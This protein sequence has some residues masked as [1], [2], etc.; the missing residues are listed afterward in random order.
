MPIP[1][2]HETFFLDQNFS[3]AYNQITVFRVPFPFER[4]DMPTHKLRDRN[5]RSQKPLRKRLLRALDRRRGIKTKP[6]KT[7][8]RLA[9]Q[10]EIE[11]KIQAQQRA[12]E[13]QEAAS[14][15]RRK[16]PPVQTSSHSVEEEQRRRGRASG[17]TDARQGYNMS[18]RMP[19]V[20]ASYT[21]EFQSAYLEAY[22]AVRDGRL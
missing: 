17:E 19:Q 1:A 21:D 10:L 11:R 22:Q 7:V 5:Q 12:R 4:A 9:A 2:L 3:F 6:L 20:F 15:R 8:I 13:R 16:H 14:A 18:K